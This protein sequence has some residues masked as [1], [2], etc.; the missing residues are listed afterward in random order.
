MRAA[1]VNA[2][3][4]GFDIEDIDIAR[5][6]GREVLVDV[7]ASGLCHSDLHFA[8]NDFGMAPP[9]VLGHEVSGIVAAVGPEVSEFTV[10]DHVVGS[11]VQFCGA[12]L[13]CLS[14]RTVS[15]LR[16]EATLRADGAPP[17]LSRRGEP[18]LAAMGTAGFAE[19]ALIHENQLVCIDPAVPFPEASVLG[20]GTITGAGAVL[21]AAG[22]RAGEAVAVI[23]L[24]GVGLNVVSGARLVGASRII[25]IDLNDEKLELARAFGVTDGI[26]A[27]EG[28]VVARVRELT[29]G[30]VDHA[31]EVIGRKETAE[32]AIAML[33]VGGTASLIGIHGAGGMVEFDANGLLREQKKVNG[34]YM[35]S[36]NIKHDI[37]LY[38]SLFLQGRLNLSD[39]IASEIAIDE[40]NEAY[41]ELGSGRTARTVITRF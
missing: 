8:V 26:N 4:G 18:I 2:F 27:G 37:P 1:I 34:V 14:G 3:G 25:G 17:R 41:E 40:I 30:G 33:R 21:N 10:G 11:L 16:P 22:V 36:A 19:Q 31:F 5:P 7:K 35:G 12:C 38:A 29:G 23:G 39:L 24:G 28:D 20:C 13:E 9:M 32:Q 15:C 6:I